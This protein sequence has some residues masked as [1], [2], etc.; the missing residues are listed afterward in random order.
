MHRM[1]SLS[2]QTAEVALCGEVVIYP[3]N[4]IRDWLVQSAN[5]HDW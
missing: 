2:V 1:V 5:A 3:Y 4:G